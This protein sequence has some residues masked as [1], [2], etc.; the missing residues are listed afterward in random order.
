VQSRKIIVISIIWLVNPRDKPDEMKQ[1]CN[2]HSTN[3][4][5]TNPKQNSVNHGVLY[6]VTSFVAIPLPDGDLPTLN[7]IDTFSS[8][9]S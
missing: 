9:H 5:D 1:N 4:T 7:K 6:G 3:H 2:W 8:I